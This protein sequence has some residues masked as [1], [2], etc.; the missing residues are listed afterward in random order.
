MSIEE[1]RQ[2][3]GDSWIGRPASAVELRSKSKEY[4]LI[5]MHAISWR[6]HYNHVNDTPPENVPFKRL[7]VN[8]I[9]TMCLFKGIGSDMVFQLHFHKDDSGN[10]RFGYWGMSCDTTNGYC[11]VAHCDN[12]ESFKW[13]IGDYNDKIQNLSNEN[14]DDR[15]KALFCF[16]IESNQATLDSTFKMYGR[17]SNIG[18]N[19]DDGSDND[20]KADNQQRKA[21]LDCDLDEFKS[22]FHCLVTFNKDNMNWRKLFYDTQPMIE[23]GILQAKKNAKKR[24]AEDGIPITAIPCVLL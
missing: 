13:I 4:K 18:S 9:D 19:S 8:H 22:K 17:S 20:S 12:V 3:L 23:H 2:E 11:W 21:R 15:Y 5:T 10:Y 1:K 16:V 14:D 7:C 6:G 24:L